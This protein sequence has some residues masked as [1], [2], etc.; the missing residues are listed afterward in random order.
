MSYHCGGL[1]I[2]LPLFAFNSILSYV[3]GLRLPLLGLRT[4]IPHT[5]HLWCYIVCNLLKLPNLDRSLCVCLYVFHL[6]SECLV[7][8]LLRKF[9][10]LFFFSP[11]SFNLFI[12][13]L[14]ALG[15]RCCVWTF[16][17]CTEQGLLSGLVL[18][19]HLQW[20]PFLGRMGSR[21][22]DFSSCGLRDLQFRH[23]SCGAQA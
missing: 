2:P 17:S 23:S 8:T 1:I 10:P 4:K 20:L 15:L 9:I 6:L 3:R 7:N 22:A 11:H 14:A 18:G 19:L 21:C 13:S 16:P 5:C 12:H